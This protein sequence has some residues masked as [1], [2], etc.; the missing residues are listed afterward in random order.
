MKVFKNNSSEGIPINIF[1]LPTIFMDKTSQTANKRQLSALQTTFSDYMNFQQYEAKSGKLSTEVWQ[2]QIEQN[3][4]YGKSLFAYK[5]VVHQYLRFSQVLAN[6]NITRFWL[7][8]IL[9]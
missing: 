1:D 8:F 4:H 7:K 5:D 2:A 9:N 3:N 6:S